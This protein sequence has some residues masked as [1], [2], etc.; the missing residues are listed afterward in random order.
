MNHVYCVL[1]VH[2]RLAALRA[3]I[4]YLN[5]QDYKGLTIV[6][7]DDGSTDGTSDYLSS[8]AQA[9]V[10]VLRGHG[11][12]WWSRAMLLGMKHVTRLANDGDYLLMLNDDVRFETGYVSALVLESRSHGDAVVGSI[13]RAETTG[14]DLGCG[15][16]IDLMKMA[17][18]PMLG[19]DEGEPDA[20]PA[21]GVLFPIAVVRR[22]GFVRA[23]LLPHYL[24]DC[25]YSARAKESGFRLRVSPQAVVFSDAASSDDSIR[26]RGFIATFF[27]P[28]SKRNVI[29]KIVFF[30]I[31]GP[32]YL[33]LSALP[34]FI[35]LGTRRHFSQPPARAR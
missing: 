16:K 23:R 6:V 9:N 14:E 7:V 2:N 27:H 1:P 25:D 17:L 5:R 21:R 28:R 12:L 29:H 30:S 32:L 13:Q 15:Y 4:G 34:R 8:L 26:Q 24:A 31:R 22:I 35:L 20:V 10:N 33:R 18:R 11:N 19:V 3:C